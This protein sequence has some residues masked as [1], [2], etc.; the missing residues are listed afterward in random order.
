MTEQLLFHFSLS[1]IGEGNGNPLQCSWRIPGTEEP[2]GLPSMGSHR[3]RCNWSDLAAATAMNNWKFKRASKY[4]TYFGINLINS[5]QNLYSE[6]YDILTKEIRVLNKWRDRLCSW[7]M[8]PSIINMPIL[9]MLIYKFNVN[10]VKIPSEFFG[11]SWWV[12]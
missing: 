2:G 3:V 6:K 1:C 7:I 12:N 9:P 8:K 10:S 5:V 11:G 4:M